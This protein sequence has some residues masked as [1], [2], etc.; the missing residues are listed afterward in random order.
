MC[1]LAH[2]QATH[3]CT[4]PAPPRPPVWQCLY[5]PEDL[6]HSMV[7]VGYGSSE[8]GDYWWVA[9]GLKGFVFR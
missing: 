6:D 1:D 7:L 2:L 3:A 5:K 9:A 4:H 8:A